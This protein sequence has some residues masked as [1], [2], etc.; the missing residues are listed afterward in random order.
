MLRSCATGATGAAAGAASIVA[1]NA[2]AGAAGRFVGDAVG[3]GRGAAG[4][5]GGLTP[6]GG[7]DFGPPAAG[8]TGQDGPGARFAVDSNGVV[9]DLS[10]NTP[11]LRPGVSS[12]APDANIPRAALPD[13]TNPAATGL[14]WNSASR[15]TFGHTFSEHGASRSTE[16]LTDRARGTGNPQGQWLDDQAAANHLR[17]NYDATPGAREIAIANGIGQ[18]IRPDGTVVAATR[19][20]VVVG[21]NGTIRSAF[22]IL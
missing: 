3:F 1:F 18:V 22:P 14:N 16:S 4:G 2:V 5:R 15:P 13:G 17:V 19:A 7:A 21:P 9:V 6:G 12:F 8:R 10:P 20:R 11:P